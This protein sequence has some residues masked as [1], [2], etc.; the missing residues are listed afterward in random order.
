MKMKKSVKTLLLLSF[1]ALGACSTVEGWFEEDEPL[2]AELAR[3][4]PIYNSSSQAA[5]SP[6]L[7]PMSAGAPTGMSPMGGMGAMGGG[8]PEVPEPPV[9]IGSNG[10]Q[11]M[12]QPSPDVFSSPLPQSSGSLPMSSPVD[13]SAAENTAVGL[14]PQRRAPAFNQ[15]LATPN[16]TPFAS[17]TPIPQPS[18]QTESMPLPPLPPVQA[19][20]EFPVLA[21]IPQNP[22]P[23]ASAEMDSRV[24][25]MKMD[26]DAANNRANN[27]F[28]QQSSQT[29]TNLA[30]LK[31]LTNEPIYKI[32]DEPK[33]MGAQPRVL[34]TQPSYASIQATTRLS[35]L[36]PISGGTRSGN[37]SH[38]RDITTLM[39]SEARHSTYYGEY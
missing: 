15:A 21:Q 9:F 39:R 7:D 3:R 32:V 10:A 2:P 25:Q 20:N 23:P 31:P 5:I 12:P 1:L 30:N 38:K 11:Q 36:R 24:Q 16:A 29:S 17:S 34:D 33:V 26:L 8:M 19:P 37:A 18:I 35:D 6:F 4:T 22:T 27:D 13:M 28:N 14:P